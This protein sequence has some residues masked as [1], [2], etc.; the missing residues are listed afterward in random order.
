MKKRILLTL[1]ALSMVLTLSP[2]TAAALSTNGTITT[3]SGAELSYYYQNGTVI[4]LMAING[5]NNFIDGK[6]ITAIEVPATINGH[7]V[8][9]IWY[10]AFCN[11]DTNRGCTNLTSVTLPATIEGFLSGGLD[12][13]P[14]GLGACTD[15]E[16]ITVKPGGAYFFTENGILYSNSYNDGNQFLEGKSLVCYPAGRKDLIFSVPDGVVAIENAF[17]NCK[18]LTNVTLPDSLI[19]IGAGAFY[20][21]PELKS[22]TIPGDVTTIGQSAFYNCRSLNSVI[23]PNKITSIKNWT[24]E[25]CTSL[26][27]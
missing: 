4:S 7:T 11:P 13:G 10:F 8:D 6:Y 5:C 15:L 16:K 2:G 23:I 3:A 19:T 9:H 26:A 21:C 25:G 1:L 12:F 14:G 24:F 22:V 17:T 27:I 20:N 18:N